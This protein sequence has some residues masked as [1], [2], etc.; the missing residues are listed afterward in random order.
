MKVSGSVRLHPL[1]VNTSSPISILIVIDC[2]HNCN[3]DIDFGL[4]TR[5]IRKRVREGSVVC[6]DCGSRLTLRGSYTRKPRGPGAPVGPRITRTECSACG[7][8]HS[9]IPSVLTPRSPYPQQVR[10]AVVQAVS[11][12]VPWTSSF[13]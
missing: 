12:R 6:P 1:P 5:G 2:G 7:S 8:S 10:G 13:R 3:G 11:S 9:L 4:V